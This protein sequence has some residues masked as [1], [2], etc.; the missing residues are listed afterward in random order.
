MLPIVTVA[1]LIVAEANPDGYLVTGRQRVPYV[2][3]EG[4]LILY[5]DRH[6]LWTLLFAY[7]GTGPPL[8]AGIVVKKADGALA[9][10]EAGPDDTIWVELIDLAPRLQKFQGTVTIRPC[11]KALSREQS[12]ALTTFAAQQQGKRYAIGRLLLQGTWLR[13]RGPLAP[14]LAQTVLDRDAWIC[15]ELAIAAASVAGLV[16]GRRVCANAVFPRDLVDNR[17][18]DLA[19]AWHDAATLERVA[20]RQASGGR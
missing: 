1:C 7:A 5:D 10:L 3:R 2:P 16:D 17:T 14:L 12:Q 6:L 4:D 8:H 15:S 20:P 11:K 9:V 19:A 18:H 13:P